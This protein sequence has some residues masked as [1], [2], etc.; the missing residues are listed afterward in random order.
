ME[1][2]LTIA[3]IGAG[4]SGMTA[5]IAAAKNGADV[6]LFEK[7]ERVGKKILA[8]GNGKCNLS[9]LEFSLAHYYCR[10][11]EKL[12][13][14]FD[15]FSLWD[16][17]AF[18]ESMGLMVKAK[19]GGYLYPYSEQASSVLDVLRMEL[20]RRGVKTMTA[21][22]I[23][24]ADYSEEKHM[25]QLKES[26]GKISY[27]DRLIVAC[28]SPASLKKDEGKSGY[29]FAKGFGHKINP[30]VPGLV[31]LKSEDSFIK[32]L[33]GVRCQASI[34][35]M[36]D[37]QEKG[38]ETGELQFTEYGISGIPVFQISR[39]AGYA[40]LENKS[41]TVQVDFFPE[42]EKKMY[43][44]MAKLRY[45][46][47]KYKTLEDYLIGTQNKKI[48]MV[49]IKQAG[50]KPGMKTGEL[51]FKEVWS[52]VKQYKAF[53][54]HISGVNSM[55]NAQVCAGGVDFD[56]VN[57]KLE[58]SL[59]K[60]L[61]FVGEMLDVDGRCGGYNLQ[62]AWSSGYVAG[63]DAAG[64]DEASLIKNENID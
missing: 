63:R 46:E 2:K 6:T 49:M 41:V 22:E 3:V 38:Q 61:Y 53:P 37:G 64:G 32:A 58:S 36:V 5:A 35:L 19:N 56:Q 15:L 55:E 4:A 51:D 10:D 7:N 18:F 1:N 13:E 34:K 20:S 45:E 39:V 40:L 30:I 52:I 29:E 60:G 23:I 54:I 27:F 8:T 24:C 59:V 43:G 42:H 62:W 33:A 16:A 26:N 48:N 28:G 25:F 57:A 12:K 44:Y 21:T 47:Q 31:Q 11:K 50:F 14:V 9:N 17:V